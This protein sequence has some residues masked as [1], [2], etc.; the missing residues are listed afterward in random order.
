MSYSL[1]P[2]SESF[3]PSKSSPLNEI[4]I[5]R[6]ENTFLKTKNE[7]LTKR[8]ENLQKE[9]DLLFDIF[10]RVRD[11]LNKATPYFNW[12]IGKLQLLLLSIDNIIRA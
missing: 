7:F 6:D 9:R 2:S 3:K 11:L 10:I 8:L 4:G 5:L 12:P 1:N